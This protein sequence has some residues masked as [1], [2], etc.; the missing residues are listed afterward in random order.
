MFTTP[1]NTIKIS[2][3]LD[4]AFLNKF[5]FEG[6][7]LTIPNSL[8]KYLMDENNRKE[9]FENFG[10]RA[11]LK[12]D[13]LKMPII[14]PETGEYDCNLVLANRIR[15]RQLNESQELKNKLDDIYHCHCKKTFL[16][17]IDEIG[18]KDIIEMIDLLEIDITNSTDVIIE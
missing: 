3:L 8:K 4:T 18:T 2:D 12:P 5:L 17:D 10:E 7:K 15:L 6:I 13:E 11:F 1:P 14:H 9:M 16:V